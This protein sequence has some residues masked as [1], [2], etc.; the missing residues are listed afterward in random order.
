MDCGSNKSPRRNNRN[1]PA[2]AARVSLGARARFFGVRDGSDFAPMP[3][4]RG[5]GRYRS[6]PKQIGATVIFECKQALCDLRRDNCR[7][8]G[9]AQA[10]RSDL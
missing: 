6:V 3:I 9:R 7:Q 4:S 5:R 1:T 8:R 2:E 10:A